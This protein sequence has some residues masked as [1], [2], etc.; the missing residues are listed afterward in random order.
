MQ[1]AGNVRLP[2]EASVITRMLP[3]SLCIHAQQPM[4]PRGEAV[5]QAFDTV[6][7]MLHQQQQLLPEIIIAAAALCLP[8]IVDSCWYKQNAIKS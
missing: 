1:H 8:R 2:V 7:T 3:F 5:M 4:Q 6:Y